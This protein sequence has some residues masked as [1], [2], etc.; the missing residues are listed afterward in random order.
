MMKIHRKT[1]MRKGECFVDHLVSF[2]CDSFKL[3]VF[4]I[5]AFYFYFFAEED[6]P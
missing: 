3:L 1:F 2:V 5:S 6:S 4:K